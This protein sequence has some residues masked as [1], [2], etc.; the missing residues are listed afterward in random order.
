MVS[1]ETPVPSGLNE[2]KPPISVTVIAWLYLVVGTLGA[3]AHVRDFLGRGGF[4]LDNVIVESV[5]IV[6]IVCG[7]FLLRGQNWARWG[8]VAW[9]GFHVVLSAF[10]ELRE[11]VVHALFCAVIGWILFRPEAGRYFQRT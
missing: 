5:E 8:A 9:I 2:K 1:A 3:V 7:A 4:G 11:F 10:H 6:A